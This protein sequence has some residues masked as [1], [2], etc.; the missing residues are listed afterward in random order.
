MTLSIRGPPRLYPPAVWQVAATPEEPLTC[1]H[2]SP[3]PLG[4]AIA[5][6]QDE[7]VEDVEEQPDNPGTENQQRL[8][9][10]LG[11]D[12]PFDGLDQDAEH[13]GHGKNGVAKSPHDVRPK[14]AERA[15]PVPSDIAGPQAE[16]AYHHGQQVREDGEGVRGQGQRVAYVG[17]HELHHEEE[18]AHDAHEDESEAP[19]RVPAHGSRLFGWLLWLFWEGQALGGEATDLAIAPPGRL[20]P[21]AFQRLSYLEITFYWPL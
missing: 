4:R 15:L 12:V 5:A 1:L 19:A 14:K 13:Q 11:I 10:L 7:I 16:Q 2:A 17:D 3:G 9:C 8:L 6:V 20:S 18:D 21:S